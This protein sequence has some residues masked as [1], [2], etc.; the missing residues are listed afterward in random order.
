MRRLHLLEIEDQAWFPR[1][2]RDAVTDLLQFTFSVCGFY[3]PAVEH[4]HRAIR[5]SGAQDVVD[6][7]SGGGGPWLDLQRRLE[8]KHGMTV[9]VRLSDKY[10]NRAAWERS[11]GASDGKFTF[12]AD[13]VDAR[14]VQPELAGFRTLFTCFHHFSPDDARA[15]LADAVH[16]G[17]GIG[18]F[19]VPRR[20][21]LT[22]AL[23]FLMPLAA[24]A[25]AP[26][27][28]P[29]RWSRLL[30]T[31]VLP[32]V[33]FVLLFD[34]IVSCLRA[35]SATELAEL[36]NGVG[37]SGYRWEAGEVRRGFFPVPVTYLIGWPDDPT[38]RAA[39]TS[40]QG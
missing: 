11:R 28:R 23:C 21:A 33:P 34:G 36:A 9:R 17:E 10:P 40:D 29:F 3:K 26:F 2:L 8:A 25:F 19:E 31:Y 6:L 32:V 38:R 24:I 18:V 39:R 35:Y 13:P 7:C 22:I 20:R 1:F 5:N 15:I 16:R 37:V 27:V 30:W 4:L 14:A 12:C